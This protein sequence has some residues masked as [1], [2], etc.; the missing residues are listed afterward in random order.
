MQQQISFLDSPSGRTSWDASR[1]TKGQTF[2][3]SSK[4]SSTSPT[5]RL[6]YLCLTKANGLLPDASWEKVTAL[7]GTSMTL[8]IPAFRNAERECTL[9]QIIDLN[10]PEKYSLSPRACAGILRRAD[11]RNKELPP[12][13]REALEE[14]VGSAGGRT[15]QSLTPQR[16]RE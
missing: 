6:Q 12:I 9:S 8:N 3:R 11:R 1:P 4:R 2:G 10:A 7:P 13:L 16:E 14:V 5:P 15:Q